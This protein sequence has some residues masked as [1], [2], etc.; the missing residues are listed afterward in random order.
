M[1]WKGIFEI[2]IWDLRF[3]IYNF[4]DALISY[5]CALCTGKVQSKCAL[6]KCGLIKCTLIKCS[7]IKCALKKCALIKCALVKCAQTM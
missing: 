5:L 3:Y 4:E 6:I 1:L 7:L 2:E